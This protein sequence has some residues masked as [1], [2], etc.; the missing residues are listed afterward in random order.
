MC[1]RPAGT[2]SRN[3]VP[4]IVRFNEHGASAPAQRLSNVLTILR[5]SIVKN[6]FGTEGTNAIDFSFR[7]VIGNNHTGAHLQALGCIGDPDTVV[8][9]REG[10]DVINAL[11]LLEPGHHIECPADLE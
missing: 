6:D 8:A 11:L 4:V 2:L 7:R 5:V 10:D 1:F 3:G 9:R